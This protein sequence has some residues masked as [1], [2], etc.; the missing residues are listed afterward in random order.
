[1]GEIKQR[2]LSIKQVAQ[3]LGLKP[4]SIYNALRPD[5]KTPFPIRAKKLGTKMW[6]FDLKDVDAYMAQSND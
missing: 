5:C 6:R 2:Y 4:A 3:Y 1:M